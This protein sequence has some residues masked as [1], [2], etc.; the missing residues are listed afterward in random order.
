[1]GKEARIN[2]QKKFGQMLR[3][4][5][6][7]IQTIKSFFQG[8]EKALIAVRKVLEQFPLDEV[9]VA[10]VKSFNPEILEIIKNDV[11][12]TLDPNAE[13]YK[14]SD[15]WKTFNFKEQTLDKL[16]LDIQSRRLIVD[17]F[18]QQFKYLKGEEVALDIIFSDLVYVKG[19]SVEQGIIEL[20]ARNSIIDKV[21]GLL[22]TLSMF[23]GQKEETVEEAK[24]RLFAD[25]NK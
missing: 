6:A 16:V 9:E 13:P 7:Q 17:Y 22:M 15:W 21:E 20:N 5:D 10:I 14:V 18:D 8:N 4:D 11:Y 1:M 23:A 3:Y 24:A 19:R 12:P 2:A 25:S